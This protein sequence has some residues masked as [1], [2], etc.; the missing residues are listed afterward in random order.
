MRCPSIS[1]K[2]QQCGL[3]LGHYGQHQNGWAAGTW[4][5]EQISAS[6]AKRIGQEN[7]NA[8]PTSG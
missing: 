7:E 6:P 8:R 2:G 5:D 3:P 4:S 1:P